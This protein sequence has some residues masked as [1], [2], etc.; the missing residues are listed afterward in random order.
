MIDPLAI[1]NFAGKDYRMISLLVVLLEQTDPTTAAQ[2]EEGFKGN[3]ELLT[4]ITKL[5]KALGKQPR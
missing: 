4:N 2:I 5:R 1:M 3:G